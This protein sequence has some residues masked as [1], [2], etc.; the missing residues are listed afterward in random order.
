MM[1]KIAVRYLQIPVNDVLCVEIVDATSYLSRIIQHV[2]GRNQA[3]LLVDDVIQG[4]RRTELEHNGKVWGIE[5]HT[6][7]ADDV[8]VVESNKMLPRNIRVQH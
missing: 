5:T 6:Q 4:A 1:H 7:H 3:L 2:L 8:G